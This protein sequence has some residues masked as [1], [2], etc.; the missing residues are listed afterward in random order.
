MRQPLHGHGVPLPPLLR[1]RL[2]QAFRHHQQGE[3]AAAESGYREILSREPRCFDAAHLL[4]VLLVQR[5]AFAE[6]IAKLREAIAID[7]TQSNAHAALARALLDT[8]A[9]DAALESCDRLVAAEPSSADA[10]FLR[11]NAL[12]QLGA[13][14]DA[15]ENYDRALALQPNFPAALNNQGH[16]LRTL[17]SLERSL[18]A[19]QRALVLQPAY[20][21]ALNNR[22]LAL[23][24]LQRMSEALQSFED[25]LALRPAFPEALANRGAALLALKRFEEA[26]DTFERL[27]KIAPNFGGALGSLLYARRNCCDWRDYE[28]LSSRVVAGV[29]R[30][31]LADLPLAFLCVSESPRA[32]LMCASTFVAAK[33]PP[34]AESPAR[35]PF[36]RR[37]RMRIAYLSG[38]FGEH[39]VSYA[40]AGV[41]ERHDVTRFEAVGVGWGRQRQ[42]PTRGRLERAFGEFID[43][44]E[45]SDSEIVRR[46]RESEID[47]AID[48]MGH[49][50]G[51][52]TGIFAQRCAPLQVNYLGYPGTTGARY[53]D[54]I[55]AD[56]CVIPEGEESC[57]S[58]SVARLSCC[59]LPND[60][61]RSIASESLT[62]ARAGL[63]ES[64]LVFCAF[65]NLLK[66]TP[67][68]FDVWMHV[69]REASGA[70]LWLREGAPE[71]RLN[72]QNAARERGI[73][74]C[75]LVFAGPMPA[76]LHLARHQLAD[77]FLDT[78][79]YN[80]HSTVCDALWA[81][82]P[83]LTCR[84]RSFASRVGA[85]LLEF[86]GLPEMIAATLDEYAHS[87]LSLAREPARLQDIRQRLVRQRTAGTL[88]NTAEY[89]R[90]FEATL[91]SMADRQR[92]G[93]PPAHFRP[94]MR[95]KLD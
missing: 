34:P 65:N 21:S 58:E 31:E 8:R 4:G 20:P 46:L 1:T 17:N 23:L 33:F 78:L 43:A 93:L 92:R 45:L 35:F 79:P 28:E 24:D 87:A 27:V 25:A 42:G 37:G 10:W 5:G 60:D 54:Y 40:L 73:E 12:Q 7:G 15:I 13:H 94:D 88:L 90:H 86:V 81:G 75:R 82:L 38:D 52:R 64:G 14:R 56:D 63:P 22:G 72:L 67:A 53:M 91:Q 41:L 62:R 57:Y 16:S 55:I 49:T 68:V 70:V 61:Q 47:I 32:Q 89:C 48:L 80:G 26:A 85:S 76:E 9:S 2:V 95:R 51:Q 39:A 6:G 74:P 77:L 44:S 50:S 84:G 18:E 66:I 59:Y 11:G 71:A 3:M 83:V 29:Q 36:D 30:G 69:L 19:F